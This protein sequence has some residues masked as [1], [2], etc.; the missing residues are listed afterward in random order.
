VPPDFPFIGDPLFDN[1]ER[2]ENPRFAADV[3]AI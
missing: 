2:G 3:D 1:F